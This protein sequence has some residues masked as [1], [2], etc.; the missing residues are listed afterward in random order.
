MNK[1]CCGFGHRIVFSNAEAEINKAVKAMIEEQGVTVFLT[2]GMGAFDKLFSQ[3]VRKMKEQY[4]NVKLVLVKPYMSEELN[5]N[6]KLYEEEYDS[7]VIPEELAEVY[8]KQAITKRNK[9]I[10]ENSDYIVCYVYRDH[11]GAFE[12]V[13][14]AQRLNKEIINVYQKTEE[15]P[16]EKIERDLLS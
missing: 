13:K 9:W 15:I 8:F 5:R 16:F 11:G 3:A 12:A 1:V 10:V 14:Y 4:P 7:V 2:G 6:K